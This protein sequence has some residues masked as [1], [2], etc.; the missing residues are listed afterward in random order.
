MSSTTSAWRS[1]SR[2][3]TLHNP[4][5]GCDCPSEAA[6]ASCAFCSMR[7]RCRRATRS[8]GRNGQSAAALST[9]DTSGRLLAAQSRA[10]RMPASGPGKSAIV[11]EM[12]GSPK[13]AK[14]AGSP[15]ALR[16][17]PSHC[18]F[19]RAI[20]R[21]RMV[22]P[23]VWRIGLSPPP[24]RRASPPASKTPG[25]VGA[26]LDVA[27]ASLDVAPI[28]LVTV[29]ALALVAGGLF[30]D[31]SKVLIVDDAAFARQ[32]DEAFAPRAPDQRQTH[33]PRQIDAPR[34]E[35]R[36][37]QQNR[38]AHSHRLDHHLGGQPSRGVENLVGGIDAMA[39]NPARDLV[40][41]V[42]AADVFGVA[43]RRT[44]FAQYAAVD[45]AGLEIK[46]G[47]RVDRVRHP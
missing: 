24:I 40:D 45:R 44:F 38:N 31:E 47:H 19:S 11:S 29:A 30:F 43:D 34:R 17:S 28:S 46:R 16:M 20:T 13:L 39:V 2:K 22:R 12:T 18:G 33:L 6:T 10:A 37:R 36:A 35:A 27:G 8:R 1:S 42:V 26:S 4:I 41:G 14:R 21:D 23:P 7:A 3:L 32:R 25:V 9:H 15:L 5:T